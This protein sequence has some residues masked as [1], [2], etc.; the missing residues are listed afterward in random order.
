MIQK[1]IG[2]CCML[3]NI[4]IDEAE[5]INWLPPLELDDAEVNKPHEPIQQEAAVPAGYLVRNEILAYFAQELL[6]GE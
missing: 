1:I 2:V 4:S 6:F 3:H 5:D